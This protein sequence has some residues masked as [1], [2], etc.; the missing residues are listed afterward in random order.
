MQ[1]KFL[2]TL[3]FLLCLSTFAS[4]N[5]R[6]R[7]NCPAKGKYKAAVERSEA[8]SEMRETEH[9]TVAPI[10]SSLPILRLLSI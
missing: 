2:Y 7:F 1:L 10:A 5:E 6:A 3:S 9:G 8:C 4:S